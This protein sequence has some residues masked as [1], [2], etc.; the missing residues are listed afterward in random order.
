[1]N[2]SGNLPTAI[3]FETNSECLLY[4]TIEV[5]KLVGIDETVLSRFIKAGELKNAG[6]YEAGKDFVRYRNLK[7][8]FPE[9]SI[10]YLQNFFQEYK[11]KIKD[12]RNNPDLIEDSRLASG[13][14]FSS[15]EL[16][17][18]IEKGLWEEHVVDIAYSPKANRTIYFFGRTVF[19][20]I[21]YC[22]TNKIAE[23]VDVQHTTIRKFIREGKLTQPDHLIGTNRWDIEQVIYDIAQLTK[24]HQ[25]NMEECYERKSINWFSLLSPLIQEMLDDYLRERQKGNG[26]RWENVTCY[27]YP[28]LTRD[29]D[30]ERLKKDL[31]RYLVKIIA[32]KEISG[33][34][35]IEVVPSQDESIKNKRNNFRIL[36]EK[37]ANVIKRKAS[38]FDLFQLTVEDIRI[39]LQGYL[40]TTQYTVSKTFS[41]FLYFLMSKWETKYPLHRI[42]SDE[43]YKMEYWETRTNLYH[44]REYLPK[45]E[46]KIP[47]SKMRKKAFFLRYEIIRVFEA[48]KATGKRRYPVKMWRRNAVMWMVGC[49]A[50]IRPEEIRELRL[51]H[52]LLDEKTGLLKT[53]NERGYGLLFI[54]ELVSKG[55]YSPSHEYGTLIVPLLVELINE[56]LEK[57]LY[58]TQ[59]ERGVGYLFRNS[60]KMGDPEAILKHPTNWISEIKDT[61]N[62]IDEEM[63]EMWKIFQFKSS[64]H[65]LNDL[66]D[67]THLN[68]T[69]LNEYKK[70]AGQIQMRHDVNKQGGT[71]GD[72]HYSSEIPKGCFYFCVDE[73]LNF[74]WNKDALELW[75]KNK[76]YRLSV[77]GRTKSDHSYEFKDIYELDNIFVDERNSYL[78]ELNSKSENQNQG[79][80]LKS[81]EVEALKQQISEQQKKIAELQ[82]LLTQAQE[83]TAATSVQNDQSMHIVAETAM[84]KVN[85][86]RLK[87]DSHFRKAELLNELERY[88]DATE[89]EIK[90]MPYKERASKINELKHELTLHR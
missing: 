12:L 28:I 20:H 59:K 33:E 27:D 4:R 88:R 21:K 73:I 2:L 31:S 10:G 30:R 90:K 65:S 74:P 89:K 7:Y 23:F 35:L 63:E 46:P 80:E 85:E 69:T 82:K 8:L 62:E 44:A 86:M 5:A 84:Q 83:E 64:R 66:F 56:Y 40:P 38:K 17:Q 55:A 77:I 43:T 26:F 51:E 53:V 75:E 34:K 39:L 19:K 32:G 11:R 45:K 48:I 3:E 58:T 50:G 76:G 81:P 24:K 57:V 18:E 16:L 36:S 14:G 79:I 47:K 78:Y 42:V 67:K 37:D 68:Y 29:K 71:I 87:V 60:F 6:I 49:F 22:C 61:L 1:M 13:M 15:K 72:K 70:R 25:K 54:P 52:F 41:P 9:T